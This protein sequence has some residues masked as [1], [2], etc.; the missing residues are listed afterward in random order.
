MSKAMHMTG[1]LSQNG[2]L[3]S[4]TLLVPGAPKAPFR[5]Q[6]DPK[7]GP[8][9]AQLEPK[10]GPRRIIFSLP[11]SWAS[12]ERDFAGTWGPKRAHPGAS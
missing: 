7:L 10:W 6:L 3:G 11:K 1:R 8:H 2:R 9:G 4:E 12:A 5:S